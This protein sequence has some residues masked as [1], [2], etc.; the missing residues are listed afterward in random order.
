MT[1][2]ADAAPKLSPAQ[3]AEMI[4]KAIRRPILEP[5]FKSVRRSQCIEVY[6]K[7][8]IVSD[9]RKKGTPFRLESKCHSSILGPA[10]AA[11]YSQNG[12]LHFI[13]DMRRPR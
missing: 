4:L 7:R 1:A 2:R 9:A 3:L 10:D 5:E 11:I 12:T 8:R 6:L 13:F